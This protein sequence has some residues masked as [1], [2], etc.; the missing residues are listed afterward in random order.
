[1]DFRC[2]EHYQPKRL[3]CA[4]ACIPVSA[5]YFGA[6]N[7]CRFASDTVAHVLPFTLWHTVNCRRAWHKLTAE[8]RSLKKEDLT[9][10][11]LARLPYLNGIIQEGMDSCDVADLGLRINPAVSF[12]HRREVSVGSEIAGHKVPAGVITVT[13]RF[14]WL[15]NCLNSGLYT[16]PS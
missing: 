8:V 16:S 10:T 13:T 11:A 6:T 14:S 15:D 3:A 12:G 5:G 2:S 7:N 9:M 1:M 4:C